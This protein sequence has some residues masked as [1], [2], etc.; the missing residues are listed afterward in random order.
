MQNYKKQGMRAKFYFPFLCPVILFR[1]KSCKMI[2]LFMQL[3]YRCSKK[4][5]VFL[6]LH[7]KNHNN[8]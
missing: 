7:N 4:E 5:I 1:L 8:I 6:L 2:F 3:T